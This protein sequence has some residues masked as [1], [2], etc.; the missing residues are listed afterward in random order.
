MWDDPLPAVVFGNAAEVLTPQPDVLP[1][2]T[3][4]P[5]ARHAQSPPVVFPPVPE[6][7]SLAGGVEGFLPPMQQ[8]WLGYRRPR[9][10]LQVWQAVR[11]VCEVHALSVYGMEQF[12]NEGGAP[13]G[14]LAGILQ[15]YVVRFVIRRVLKNLLQQRIPICAFELLRGKDEREHFPPAVE[16]M[17]AVDQ[18]A[19]LAPGVAP[20]PIVLK[21]RNAYV[22][23]DALD[24][25]RH[26][27]A[28]DDVLGLVKVQKRHVAVEPQVDEHED[29]V[30]D[31]HRVPQV[32]REDQLGVSRGAA[33]ED[34]APD[35]DRRL[36]AGLRREGHG[37]KEPHLLD[38][39]IGQC[40][41]QR[42][43]VP[44]GHKGAEARGLPRP[45]ALVHSL[46]LI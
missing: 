5:R 36:A 10:V 23:L 46:D 11:E 6:T 30:D 33:D 22:A 18:D 40:G 4:F 25:R 28:P 41:H 32:A 14:G 26:G 2:H 29:G 34:V 45:I 38:A 24:R 15:S 8:S 31:Q 39:R 19:R 1:R 21:R 7:R 20:R 12:A 9:S 43:R 17:D 37:P 13:K 44:L 27:H 3:V 42:I 35:R 16:R